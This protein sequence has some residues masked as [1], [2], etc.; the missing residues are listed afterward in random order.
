MPVRWP[1]PMR[2]EQENGYTVWTPDSAE[3]LVLALSLTTDRDAFLFGDGL[4]R[5]QRDSSWRLVSSLGRVADEDDDSV[6]W[7]EESLLDQ[8]M[9]QSAVHLSRVPQELA[10]VEWLIL[11]Q[12]YGA[13]TRLLDWT[14]SPLVG[15]FFAIE[16][17]YPSKSDKPGSCGAV[18]AL[19]PSYGS[20]LS[21]PSPSD[22]QRIH[23]D[24]EDPEGCRPVG[25]GR[26]HEETFLKAV[27]ECSPIP[28]VIDPL[29]PDGR[30]LAQGGVLTALCSLSASLD[31]AAAVAADE[32]LEIRKLVVPLEWSYELH[33]MLRNAGVSYASLFPGIDGV[34]RAVRHEVDLTTHSVA[35]E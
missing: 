9:R 23:L 14:R 6:W 24:L 34:G 20:P 15:L 21:P 32:R 18:W 16:G 35:F 1:L 5:G 19:S 27:D 4:Y 12:H 29:Y 26:W 10:V 8:F 33:W 30:M 13:P 28:L 2:V 17:C 3:E 11:M 7:W 22:G 25:L 31:P